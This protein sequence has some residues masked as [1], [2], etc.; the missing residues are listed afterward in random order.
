VTIGCQFCGFQ[1]NPERVPRDDHGPHW[2]FDPGWGACEETLTDLHGWLRERERSEG[3]CKLRFHLHY[4]YRSGYTTEDHPQEVEVRS[5][6]M[7]GRDGKRLDGSL[8]EVRYYVLPLPPP[9]PCPVQPGERILR[10][11]RYG[12]QP[13]SY[14][15]DEPEFEQRDG[16]YSFRLEPVL[17]NASHLPPESREGCL[18]LPRDPKA[19]VAAYGKV[20]RGLVCLC[21]QPIPEDWIAFEVV[22]VAKSQKAAFVKPVRGNTAELLA[23]YLIPDG[24]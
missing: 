18:V 15:A 6:R 11:L 1:V 22:G 20:K 16:T 5:W 3:E 8:Q 24:E 12:K 14:V 2:R 10:P 23:A 13:G 19:L 9:P 21:R 17:S 4:T 7:F